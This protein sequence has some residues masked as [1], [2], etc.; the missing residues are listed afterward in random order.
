[1]L[2]ARVGATIGLDVGEK[3]QITCLAGDGQSFGREACFTAS[4][5]IVEVDDRGRYALIIS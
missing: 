4:I 5:A 2:R 3:Q 1:M